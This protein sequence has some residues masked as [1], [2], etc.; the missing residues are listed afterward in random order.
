MMTA[1]KEKVRIRHPGR[2]HDMNKSAPLASAAVIRRTVLLVYGFTFIGTLAWIGAIFLAPYLKSRSSGAAAS[3]L[4]AIFS[5][6]CHQIPSRSFYFHGFPLAVCGRCLGI[7]AGFLAGLVIYP[8][9][10]GFSKIALPSGRLFILLSLPVGADFVGGLLGL[11][12]S[13]NWIRFSTGFLWGVILPFYFMTGVSEL[14]LRRPARKSNDEP[15]PP[16]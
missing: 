12:A 7:Y 15:A 13:P 16:G 14:L 8:F 11:W 4:Y 2:A 9:A 10:R 5:P 3:F 1:Q 6:V